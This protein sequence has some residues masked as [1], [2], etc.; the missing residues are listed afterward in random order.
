MSFSDHSSGPTGREL[1][2]IMNDPSTVG[3]R[4]FVG[5]IPAKMDKQELEDK[6][7]MYGK[8]AGKFIFNM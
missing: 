5:N 3:A 7:S 1:F 2:N 6:F 8:I 4:I